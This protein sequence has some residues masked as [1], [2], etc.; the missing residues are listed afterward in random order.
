VGA[1]PTG[2]TAA[3]ELARR[4]IIPTVIDR[5]DGPSRL[6]R[7]V[8]ILPGSM[9]IL[10]RSGAGAAIRNEA[11]AFAGISIHK[12]ARRVA[13]IAM[14]NDARARLLGL[15]QDRTEAHIAAALKRLGGK[16]D[17]ERELQALEQDETGILARTDRDDAYFDYVIGADGVQSTVRGILGL[18]FPGYDLPGLWSIADVECE[19][20]ADPLDFH[21][22]LLPRGNVAV[23]VPLAEHRFRVIASQPDALNS[24]PQRMNIRRVRRTGEFTISVR[25]V[26]RYVQ[27]R[28]AL[29]GDAAHC[30]S[31]VGG[32][33]MNLGIADAADL[34]DRIGRDTLNGYHDAR[35]AAGAQTL[36]LSE[37]GRRMVQDRPRIL[38][39]NLLRLVALVPGLREA[40][41]RRIID[42]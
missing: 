29:A 4:G 2:L 24:L 30:H 27:G 40:A 14:G 33:G 10:D 37:A 41:I 13:R 15:A 35:H 34:A 42:I 18:G 31:P 26:D 19:N 12:R 9:D 28:V 39:T 22:F 20:W 6:S 16:V 5:R 1:G 23:V 3:V 7:A 8:G 32:R 17:Y 21:A 11:V 38:T 25:Q 36:A